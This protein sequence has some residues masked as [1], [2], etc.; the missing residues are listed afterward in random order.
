MVDGKSTHLGNFDDENEAASKYDKAATRTKKLFNVAEAKSP[1]VRAL[2]KQRARLNVNGFVREFNRFFENMICLHSGSTSSY[3]GVSWHSRVRKWVSQI[4]FGG[5][6]SVLGYFDYKKEAARKY[7]EVAA[8]L[9]MPLNFP[10][11][12]QVK[13]VKDSRLGSSIYNGASW[14]C[15][16]A[17]AKSPAV[18]ALKKQ[19]ASLKVIEFVREFNRSCTE[20]IQTAHCRI[21]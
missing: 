8:S 18:R 5:K 4:G 15:N 2:K 21:N 11:V 14:A 13:A 16:V 6:R 20:T 12:G 1:A 19:R 9:G 3:M 10:G 17:E 7:G